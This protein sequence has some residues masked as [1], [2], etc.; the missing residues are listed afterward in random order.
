M[1][2]G[3]RGW[4]ERGFLP[5]RDEPGLTQFVTFRIADSFPAALRTEWG[6]LLEV[7]DDRERRKNL[8][9]Y[10]DRG[11]GECWLRQPAIGNLVEGALRFHHGTHYELRAC[12]VMANHVHVLFKVGTKPMDRVIAEWKEFTAREA[13]K[14]LRRRGQF[15][16]SD[17][18]DTY[19]R[20]SDH[21]LR[22]RR[23]TEHNPVK[24]TLVREAKEWPWSSARFRDEHGLLRL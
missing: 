17:F 23:Y 4:H 5:H 8:E 22:A 20:N 19:M 1:I 12:V 3:F 10:L 14:L 15:W 6:A 24:A 21:E 11:R 9:A 13:N 7:E 2:A 16:A 18:W